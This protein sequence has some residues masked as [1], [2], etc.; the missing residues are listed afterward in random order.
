MGPMILLFSS[1]L[2]Y[3]QSWRAAGIAWNI[4]LNYYSTPSFLNC[5]LPILFQIPFF[6]MKWKCGN[7]SRARYKSSCDWSLGFCTTISWL[8]S[9][10]QKAWHSQNKLSNDFGHARL[11]C[12]PVGLL[13]RIK[14][15]PKRNF[16]L[17][18]NFWGLVPVP[19]AYFNSVSLR[20]GFI[21]N[22][23]SSHRSVSELL[24]IA[25]ASAHS[26]FV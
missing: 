6:S 26:G 11:L 7:P 25:E 15:L 17:V 16:C 21:D 12:K 23:R 2:P 1:T 5:F 20:S 24:I 4:S 19:F 18:V 14:Q 8:L 9:A 22:V 13:K 10:P 3:A